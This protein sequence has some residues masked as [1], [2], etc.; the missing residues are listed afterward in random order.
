MLEFFKWVKGS[1][2]D[3]ILV[4]GLTPS[5]RFRHES[6]NPCIYGWAFSDMEAGKLQELRRLTEFMN[7]QKRDVRLKLLEGALLD[8][9]FSA[10]EKVIEG[11]WI[12]FKKLAERYK[13]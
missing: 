12:G 5:K 6:H 4:V 13:T 2:D 3:F 1:I 11:F 10:E 9:W 7:S 8:I